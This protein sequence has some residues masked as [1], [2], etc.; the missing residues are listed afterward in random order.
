MSTT[1]VPPTT[2][3][4][5]RQPRTLPIE[6]RVASP[7]RQLPEGELGFGR[8]FA[9]H[10]FS[11]EWTPD[12]WRDAKVQPYGPLSLDPA[13]AVLHYGQELFEGFKAYRGHDGVVRTYRLSRHCRRLAEGAARLCMPAPDPDFFEEAVRT[14]LRVDRDWVPSAPGTSLYVRPTLIACEPFLGVRPAEKY[15]FFIISSPVGAYYA[16]G[17]NPVRIWVEKKQVRAPRNGLGAVKAGANYAAGLQAAYAA[18]QRGYA[19]VLWLDANE[20]KYLEE[21]GTMNVFVRIDDELVTPPL[22]GSILAG[23]TRDSVLALAREWGLKVSERAI[24]IDEVQAAHARGALREMFGSGTAAVISP[25]GELGFGDTQLAINGGRI[26]EW[27]QRF[28]DELTGIQ[29]GRRPDPFGW[30][31]ALD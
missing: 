29:Y 12:G 10:M 28:Y 30:T 7:R 13:A 27:S 11:M 20:H 9:E 24:S 18:K 5:V 25:I 21:V 17:L 6:V 16:E 8:V 23:V 22:E 31:R 26:G 4:P 2:P 19:Q 15:L 14:L 3:L 1:F